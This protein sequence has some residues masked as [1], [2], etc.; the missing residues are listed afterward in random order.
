MSV[1]EGI[2]FI[3]GG[4]EVFFAEGGAVTLAEAWVEGCA[5]G[6]DALAAD[7]CAAGGGIGELRGVDT[8]G[9]TDVFA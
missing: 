9:P 4:V 3:G 6:A 8:D 7:E 1:G 2:A 5:E